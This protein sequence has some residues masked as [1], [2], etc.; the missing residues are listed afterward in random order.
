MNRITMYQIRL[1]NITF[2]ILYQ[3]PKHQINDKKESEQ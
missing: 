3:K 2:N 1:Q